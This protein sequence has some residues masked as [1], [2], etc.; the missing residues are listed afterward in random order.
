MNNVS[1]WIVS[2]VR[3]GRGL[4]ANGQSDGQPKE[5]LVLY[6]F[7]A[8]PFCRKV[9]EVLSELDLDYI[10][11]PCAKGSSRRSEVIDLGGRTQFPYLVDPNTGQSMYESEDIIT[12]L[13]DQYGHGRGG[14][15]KGLAPLNTLGAYAASALRPRGRRVLPGLADRSST[16][17]LTLYN[18]EASPY[19]RKV[20]ERLNELDLAYHVHSVAKKGRGRPALVERGGKMQVPYLIDPNTGTDLYESD[21]INRYLQDT[22]GPA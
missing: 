7:E 22:Y 5:P 10:C 6:E 8:C 21:D 4:R 20:R 18:F 16:E 11:Y 2:I 13:C 15:G 17:P 1:S 3:L 14:L 19:C 9:R 12:Y